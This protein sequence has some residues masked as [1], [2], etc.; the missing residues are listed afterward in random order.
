MDI[1]KRN[2]QIKQH[3]KDGLSYPKIGLTFGLSHQMVM[4]IVNANTV[5]VKEKVCSKCKTLYEIDAFAKYKYSKDGRYYECRKCVAHYR[6]TLNHNHAEYMR[7]Y[8]VKHPE[9][10]K[11]YRHTTPQN[12]QKT[13][14]R[15]ALRNAVRDKRIDK[16][17]KCNHC[18]NKRK[19]T[20]HHPDYKKPFIVIWLCNK[21]HGKMH[22]KY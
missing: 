20:A 4:R 14:C 1:E 10:R 16:P 21:C 11:D 12:T 17:E 9:R 3:R 6:R 5:I 15:D 22:R 2:G 18:G 7:K 19:I 8:R 13:K